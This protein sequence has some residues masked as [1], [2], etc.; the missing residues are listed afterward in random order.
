MMMAR[1]DAASR[2]SAASA[3]QE[4]HLGPAL[5]VLGAVLNDH[6]VAIEEYG[7]LHEG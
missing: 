7:V 5:H 6:S 1:G 4:P 3:F 2:F